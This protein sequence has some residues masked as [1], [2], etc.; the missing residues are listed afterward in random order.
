LYTHL[1]SI[2]FHKQY[3]NYYIVVIAGALE[4]ESTKYDIL[5]IN[6]CELDTGKTDILTNIYGIKEGWTEYVGPA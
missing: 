2:V 5:A 6:T 3:S 4:I 1:H